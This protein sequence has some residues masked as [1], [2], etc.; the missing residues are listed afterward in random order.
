[1]L[2]LVIVIAGAGYFSAKGCES[3][4]KSALSAA[5]EFLDQSSEFESARR[6]TVE[7]VRETA[8][9]LRNRVTAPTE[10]GE[11]A[12]AFESDWEKV[13]GDVDELHEEFTRLASAAEDYLQVL[14]ETARGLTDEAMRRREIAK[15]DRV[16]A[17]F[18][19]EFDRAQASLKQ[20]GHL[21]SDG[22]DVGRLL[23]LQATRAKVSKQTERLGSIADEAEAILRRL[24]GLSEGGRRL[25]VARGASTG[26]RASS[27]IVVQ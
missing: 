27:S 14:D 20:L 17:K 21:V 10:S 18:V 7:T 12:V 6:S 11:L 25:V 26:E 8:R 16:K 22:S 4:A 19:G 1:M 5:E 15:N 13:Q 24:E 23:I 9:N 3:Q 2:M